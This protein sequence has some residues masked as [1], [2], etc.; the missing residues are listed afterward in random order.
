MRNKKGNDY[1]ELLMELSNFSCTAVSL[2]H[3]TLSN[4]DVNKLDEK[5]V[6]MHEIEHSADIK[7]HEM[8]NKL[9]KEFITP[10]E[11]DDIIELSH[12]IDNLTDDIED[13]L[14]KIYTFNISTMRQEALDFCDLILK[15]CDKVKALMEEFQHFKKS[16]KIHIL[17]E[18][19]NSLEEEGDRLYTTTIRNLYIN[20]KDPIELMSWKDTFRY[21]EKCCDACESVATVVERVIMKNS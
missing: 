20:L 19:I 13:I 10:I 7:K 8:M 17:I 12:H 11:R 3:D 16:Q 14:V 9:I 18:D 6:E 5:I 21:F 4:F 1:F 2:L 15:G